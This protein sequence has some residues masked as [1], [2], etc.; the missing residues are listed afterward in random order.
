[1]RNLLRVPL[2]FAFSIIGLWADSVSISIGTYDSFPSLTALNNPTTRQN[3][4]LAF[5]ANHS[6]DGL[7]DPTNVNSPPR[8]NSQ[9]AIG[10]FLTGTCGPNKA[11]VGSCPAGTFDGLP[12]KP[13]RLLCQWQ[14]AHLQFLF[15]SGWQL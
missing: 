5:W 7:T 14:H 11:T 3:G 4:S 15:H 13:I 12:A 8:T 2:I 10:N 1:M 6:L 9:V